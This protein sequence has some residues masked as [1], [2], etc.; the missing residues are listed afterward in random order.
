MRWSSCNPPKTK[1]WNENLDCNRLTFLKFAEDYLSYSKSVHT[2]KSQE[3]AGT[4]LREFIRIVGNVPL[5]KVGVREIDNFLAVKKGDV[6]E[7]FRPVIE[8]VYDRKI[9][10]PFSYCVFISS[11]NVRR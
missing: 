4:S 9:W 5:H 2:R 6:S 7:Q 11:I 1:T 10:L 3:S 8:D